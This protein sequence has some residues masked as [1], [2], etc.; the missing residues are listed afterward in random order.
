M[1]QQVGTL[2][3]GRYG[4]VIVQEAAQ[5]Q[6]PRRLYE[7]RPSTPVSS[8]RLSRLSPGVSVSRVS[9]LGERATAGA[10]TDERRPET[11]EP[12]SSLT[13]QL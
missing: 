8:P 13:L 12:L 4:L 3:S 5:P 7:R 10:G 2:V 1:Y 6:R 9:A 11:R